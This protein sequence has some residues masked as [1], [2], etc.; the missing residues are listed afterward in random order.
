M[1]RAEITDHIRLS[2]L[3]NALC[4]IA[5]P[6]SEFAPS[7]FG[8]IQKAIRQHDNEELFSWLLTAFSYQG[9]SDGA[10]E[11]FIAKNGTASFKDIRD[12]I[13]QSSCS[14][15]GGFWNFHSCGFEKLQRK[16][17]HLELMHN[18]AV[19]KQPLRN[20][21]LNQLAFSL[22]FFIR[23]VAHDDLVEFLKAS[24]S[25]IPTD[26]S[27]REVHQILV[28]PWRAIYG[29][30][31]KVA[32][33][34]LSTLLLCAPRSWPNWHSA[35]RNLIVVDSLVHNFLRRTGALH[36]LGHQHAYGPG[37]YAEGGCF[38]TIGAL[39]ARVDTRRF[40]TNFPSYFPRFVQLSIWRYCAQSAWN[41]CNG[42]QI[43]DR[44]RCSGG[45][46]Y[47]RNECMRKRL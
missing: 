14:K 5:N 33:M 39:A 44:K 29:V 20:G 41:I 43:D 38:D 11:G 22:F 16:C 7:S 19:P 13:T 34:A 21:R 47:L 17:S 27:P 26:A 30:S 10:V 24:I 31:D 9:L 6:T 37:C 3:I 32:T 40:N 1:R 46:C 18:C 2:R 8:G 23:D 12:S 4:D 45:S 36:T 42:N 15:L 35:G 25:T 28:T